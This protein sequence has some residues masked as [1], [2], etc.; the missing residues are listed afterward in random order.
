MKIVPI[1]LSKK[2]IFTRLFQKS[3]A[4]YWLPQATDLTTDK[5]QWKTVPAN[6]KSATLAL[7]KFA[8]LLDSEQ[9]SAISNFCRKVD[10]P[11]LKALLSYHAMM[12]SIHSESYAYFAETVC[13]VKEKEFLYQQ[14]E[15]S[16]KRMEVFEAILKEFGA[17][18]ANYWLEAVSFQALFRL[19]DILSGQN[20]LPGLS[21]LIRLISRDEDIHQK[22][23]AA[24]MTSEDRQCVYE[25]FLKYAPIEGELISDLTGITE[26]KRYYVFVASHY[27]KGLG[28]TTPEVKSSLI[29]GSPFASLWDLGDHSKKKLKGN[30]FTSSLVYDNERPDLNWDVHSWFSSPA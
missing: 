12:E 19:A 23:F 18:T 1:D 20:L 5:M 4:Q 28:F 17:I 16:G 21:S 8:I 27:L 2:T 30:F 26:F 22:T 3:K 24:M 11:G 6:L 7:L 13:T 29:G 25:A 15:D 10:N 14:D 9:V